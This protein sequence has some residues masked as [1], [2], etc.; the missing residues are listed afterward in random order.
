MKNEVIHLGQ[1]EIKFLLEAADTTGAL[2]MF[3]LTVP[4]GAKVPVRV[5][6]WP[7]PAR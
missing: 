4:A 7:G 3:E 6:M 5:L 2:A 1:I